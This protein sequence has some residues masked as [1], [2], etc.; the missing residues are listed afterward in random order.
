V[1]DIY[2]AIE[3]IA[4]QE[5]QPVISVCEALEV[6]RSAYHAWKTKEASSREVQDAELS[7]LIRDIF[8]K[9]K[10]RYGARRIAKDLIEIGCPCDVKR[11]GKLMRNQHLVAIQPKSFVP[12][13]TDSRHTLGYSPN[14]LLEMPELVDVD[15]LWVGDITYIPLVGGEFAYLATLMDRFSRRIIAWHVAD[16]MSEDLVLPVLRQSIQERQPYP[17][18][19]HHTDRGGQYASTRYRAV[20]R[21][22]G[23][24]QSMSRAD[25]CYDNAFAESGFGTL[26]TELEMTRYESV[27]AARKEIGEFL[28]YYNL[29]RKHSSLGYQSPHQFELHHAANGTKTKQQK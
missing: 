17:G 3:V 13:T 11:V 10:R 16:H 25:N 24:V 22:A 26:K 14:L 1:T 8:W 6:S 29:E 12:K 21:R 7:P 5:S 20:L 28:A 19:I 9:H 15:Q 4:L 2:A 23:I 27:G 18:L